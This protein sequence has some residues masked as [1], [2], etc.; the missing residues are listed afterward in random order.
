MNSLLEDQSTFE[1]FLN[2]IRNIRNWWIIYAEKYGF[3]KARH[4]LLET[5]SGI[6][7][8]VP[9]LLLFTFKENFIAESYM[10][11]LEYQN[12]LNPVILDVGAN[13]GYFTLFAAS[14]FPNARI[15]AFEPIPAN[16]HQLEKNRNL[17]P[18]CDIET[19]PFA[20][21]GH[22]GDVTLSFD[23]S[24]SFTTS[25]TVYQNNDN[26]NINRITVP[27]KSL[28]DIFEE[29]G[30]DKCDLVKM[31]C[32]G[33]EFD[34]LYNAPDTIFSRIRQFAMEVHLGP[35]Q[36][37]NIVSMEAFLREKGFNTRQKFPLLWA[38]KI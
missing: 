33:A 6:K 13:A 35:K 3:T 27:C 14:R 2:L 19:F 10:R 11:G 17:N 26:Q 7:M 28:S 31:D 20:V 25:A 15:I 38:W 12:L 22:S 23:P 5:R 37:Q 16:Y 24:G 9:H 4:F 18:H 32:E 21:S 36:N 29:Q 34:I 8:D 30:I 1:R